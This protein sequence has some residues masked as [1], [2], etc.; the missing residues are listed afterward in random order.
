MF[1]WDTFALKRPWRARDQ[2]NWPVA[3]LST[4]PGCLLGPLNTQDPCG[5]TSPFPL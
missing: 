1:L 2:V 5:S 3:L 4:D